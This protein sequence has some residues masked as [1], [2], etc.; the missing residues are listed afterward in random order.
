MPANSKRPA[1]AAIGQSPSLTPVYVPGTA[2]PVYRPNTTRIQPKTG[3]QPG[4]APAVYR[5]HTAA[6]QHPTRPV[7][8]QAPELYRP[9]SLGIQ[10]LGVHRP[11]TPPP[12]YR[13]HIATAQPKMAAA[14]V[15]QRSAGT[16][17]DV[18]IRQ[19]QAIVDANRHTIS[20][21]TRR[22]NRRRRIKTG[23]TRGQLTALIDALNR[24]I[25]ARQEVVAANGRLRRPDPGDHGTAIVV[26]QGLFADATA[27]LATLNYH[28]PTAWVQ[29]PTNVNR[30]VRQSGYWDR[31]AAR[32]ESRWRP[33]YQ[34]PA[35][36]VL[37]VNN[38]FALLAEE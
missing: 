12:I 13:P 10:A 16:A 28:A 38:P 17:D 20:Q 6:V 4:T 22:V 37:A 15:I 24:S 14:A 9:Q 32:A 2:P 21:H 19:Q 27:D 34:P 18:V 23:L 7:S 1:A 26:E 31:E 25:A 8:V 35:A 36:P 3:Y 30:Q 11:G 29:D 33:G 5:P